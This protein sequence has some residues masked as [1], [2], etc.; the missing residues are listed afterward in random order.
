MLATDAGAMLKDSLNG[1][2]VLLREPLIVTDTV[3][4]LLQT[5]GIELHVGPVLGQ[6]TRNLVDNDFCRLE[7]CE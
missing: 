5:L 3:T 7:L 4:N 1:A 6:R 2:S